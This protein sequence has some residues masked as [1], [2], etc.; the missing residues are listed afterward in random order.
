M[1]ILQRTITDLKGVGAQVAAR[2]A[3]LQI[4]TLQDVIFHLPYKYVDRTR[5]YPLAT[6]R[7]DDTVVI[8]A[9]IEK[10]SLIPKPKR[11]LSLKIRDSSGAAEIR[12]FHFNFQQQQQLKP[13]VTLRCFGQ[14]RLGRNGL[15]FIHPEYTVVQPDQVL[16]VEE[17][18]TPIYPTTE[19][20]TQKLLRSL[21]KQVLQVLQPIDQ[22][23]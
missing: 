15:S 4:Y 12:F 8:E 7:V 17:Y 5:I 3:K 22:S 21:V 16:P 20:V 11:N 19:G 2:L 10:V 9:Q 23:K 18:L 14:A 13:G 1:S 6:V